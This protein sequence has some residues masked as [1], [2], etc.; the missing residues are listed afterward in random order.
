MTWSCEK[1]RNQK[2]GLR[3]ADWDL[4]SQMCSAAAADCPISFSSRHWNNRENPHSPL[5]SF[6]VLLGILVRKWHVFSTHCLHYVK[7]VQLQGKNKNPSDQSA[8]H[9]TKEGAN[10]QMESDESLL[11][12][13]SETSTITVR[14]SVLCGLLLLTNACC[15]LGWNTRRGLHYLGEDSRSSTIL[16]F[17]L[18]PSFFHPQCSSN[19][20]SPHP[21]S[22]NG[23]AE[24][25]R[26]IFERMGEFSMSDSIVQT[27]K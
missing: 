10:K 21:S 22:A 15:S 25:S 23:L 3:C 12:R 14:D 5:K 1:Q 7:Q 8:Q 9:Q 2:S 26:S 4:L 11:I 13:S 16:V 17:S 6:H 24:V 19:S 27:Y 18:S 20:F